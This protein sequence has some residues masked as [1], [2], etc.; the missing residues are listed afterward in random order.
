MFKRIFLIVLDSVG[1]GEAKD[2]EYY[3][4]RGANTLLHTIEHA[5]YNL[6]ILEKFGMLNLVGKSIPAPIAFYTKC[7]PN[8]KGKD[9]L[10]GHYEMMGIYEKSPFKTFP[11]GFP[12]E[13]I[14][15]IQHK[16]GREVI[17]NIAS[18][19]TD[20]IDELGEMHIKT[21]SIIIYTSADSVLQVAAHEKVVPLKELYNICE[22]IREIT[23]REEYKVGRVIARPFTG[24][25][26]DFTRTPYRKDYTLD[27]PNNAL[28]LLYNNNLDVIALGKISDI[29]NNR[30]ITTSIK[31][32]DNIDG[33]IKL[34]DFSNASFN[35]LCF[36]NLND[37]D[38]KYGHRRN[39]DGYLKAL[40]EFDYYLPIFLKNLKK[41]DL[42]M[43]T[44]D[45]GN[46]P[47][48]KGTDHTRENVPLIM[49]S[50]SLKNTKRLED[51]TSLADI[52]ATILDNFNIPNTLEIGKSILNEI[53][54]EQSN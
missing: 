3:N 39:K 22:I 30:G 25:I 19:G 37:F 42:L 15:E 33:L 24:N 52:G 34:V 38:S 1:V 14:S 5:G 53:K 6:N 32:I 49:Y 29:F 16:T 8:N 7:L 18:S 17:G 31:T 35:G 46:D 2:A 36:L 54:K 13:L 26:G 11:D 44:A 43:I 40:E 27:P 21:G 50:P 20:I 48:F 41:D 51:R 4:D 9:T 28:D 10:N 12:L 47:T 23:S 45:H